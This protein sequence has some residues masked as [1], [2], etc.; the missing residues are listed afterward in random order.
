MSRQST[1]KAWIAIWGSFGS[2]CRKPSDL[3]IR[4][5]DRLDEARLTPARTRMEI[6]SLFEESL[7]AEPQPMDSIWREVERKIFANS[8]CP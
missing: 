4:L 5:Y 6:A 1:L 7:P 8:T 3:V 2:I